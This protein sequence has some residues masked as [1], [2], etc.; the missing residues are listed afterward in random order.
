MRMNVENRFKRAWKQ[1]SHPYIKLTHLYS[2]TFIWS[3]FFKIHGISMC[4]PG[5]GGRKSVVSRTFFYSCKLICVVDSYFHYPMVHKQIL[6]ATENSVERVK[7]AVELR[8]DKWV[9]E[10]RVSSL[11]RMTFCKITRFV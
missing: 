8:V 3:H 4:I 7:F 1:F 6:V 11:S 5:R 10:K 9:L 2:C